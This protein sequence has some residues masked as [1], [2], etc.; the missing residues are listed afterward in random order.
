MEL[1]VGD[2]AA[3]LHNHDYVRNSFGSINGGVLG[4][5]VVAAAE[6]ATGMIAA[7]LTLRYVGQT[8]VGPARASTTIVRRAGDHAVTEVSVVDTGADDLLLAH[9]IVT[10]VRA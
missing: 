4:I 9:A 8:K 2:G 10:T 1:Q 6:D 7:D 5:V 3:V